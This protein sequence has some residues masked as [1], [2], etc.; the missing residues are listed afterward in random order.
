MKSSREIERELGIVRNEHYQLVME[1]SLNLGDFE[2]KIDAL[3]RDGWRPAGGVSAV[4]SPTAGHCE[5]LYQ[6]MFRAVPDRVVKDSL[7]TPAELSRSI[8]L[9]WVHE[10]VRKL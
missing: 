9:D 6:A 8:K 3:C 7:T 1:S 2:D 4:A 5:I 10:D